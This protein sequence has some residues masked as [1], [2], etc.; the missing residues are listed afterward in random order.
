VNFNFAGTSGSHTVTVAPV[1]ATAT[2]LTVY[3]AN[4][5][6]ANVLETRNTIPSAGNVTTF[7]VKHDSAG[8]GRLAV[9]DR[10]GHETVVIPGDARGVASFNTASILM[11]RPSNGG[12]VRL[13]GNAGVGSISL[14]TN[15]GASVFSFANIGV[16]AILGDNRD[17]VVRLNNE[18]RIRFGAPGGSG[19]TVAVTGSFTASSTIQPASFTVANLPSASEAGAGAT[20]Y[21]SNGRRSGEQP[22]AGTGIPVWSDGTIWRTYYDNSV[23]AQ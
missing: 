17:I 21:A 18:E 11:A 3:G 15:A 9:S 22:G 20:A 2:G 23:V 19:S 16:N 5:Q 7:Y 6:I 4:G 12:Q 14:E 10:L 8:N 1:T 13:S